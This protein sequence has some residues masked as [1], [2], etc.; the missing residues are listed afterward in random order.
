M[1][2][3]PLIRCSKVDD[4]HWTVGAT[5]KALKHIGCYSAK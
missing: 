5:D 1:L 4:V 3:S 2:A